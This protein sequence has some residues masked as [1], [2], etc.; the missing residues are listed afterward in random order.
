MKFQIKKHK[1][2]R[3]ICFKVWNLV[4]LCPHRE[5]DREYYTDLEITY[6]P[7]AYEIGEEGLKRYIE[8]C[9]ERKEVAM[10]MV[11]LKILSY[12]VESTSTRKPG[13]RNASPI[14]LQILSTS[15]GK[16]KKW[17]ITVNLKF[18]R[19]IE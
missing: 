9:V 13:R 10:E 11:P 6:I 17:A 8:T 15:R 3:G 1:L 16:G 14:D 12:C 4:T 19:K 5:Y 2:K 7:G 18:N